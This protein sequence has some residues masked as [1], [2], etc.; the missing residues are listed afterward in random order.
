MQKLKHQVIQVQIIVEILLITIIILLII[1]DAAYTL[2][3]INII[4]QNIKLTIPIFILLL[5]NL[6]PLPLSEDKSSDATLSNLGVS[7]SK[8]DFKGFKKSTTGANGEYKVT[9]PN[10]VTKLSIYASPTSSKAK[11]W[12]TGNRGFKVGTNK[13]YCNCNFISN[14]Y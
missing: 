9:V 5:I 7:P 12:V 11:Y 10:D 13:F 6:Y 1:A 2:E 3:L 14:C 8:Y 4:K